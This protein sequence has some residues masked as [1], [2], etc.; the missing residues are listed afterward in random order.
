[1]A[2]VE[3]MITVSGDRCVGGASRDAGCGSVAI[4]VVQTPQMDRRCGRRGRNHE[5]VVKPDGGDWSVG[6][7]KSIQ[8]RSSGHRPDLTTTQH[9]YA[10]VGSHFKTLDHQESGGKNHLRFTETSSV[11][12]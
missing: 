9:S 11:H 7:T 8:Q 2:D 5:A 10:P 1:M 4:V 3:D 12:C 6:T